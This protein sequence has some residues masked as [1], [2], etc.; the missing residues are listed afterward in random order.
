MA[1]ECESAVLQ[2]LDNDN[3]GDKEVIE[4]MIF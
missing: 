3:K 2:E 4:I 1:I